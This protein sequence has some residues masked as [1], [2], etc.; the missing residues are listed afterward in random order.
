MIDRHE[1]ERLVTGDAPGAGRSSSRLVLAV[2]MLEV[3]LSSFLPRA[4]AQA[5]PSADTVVVR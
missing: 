4:T 5:A 1:I 2:L 3:W